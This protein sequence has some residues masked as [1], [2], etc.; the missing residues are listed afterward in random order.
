[1]CIAGRRNPGGAFDSKT[2][3][4]VNGH[5]LYKDYLNGAGRGLSSP[6][7][8]ASGAGR[9][10]SCLALALKLRSAFPPV[11]P[12]FAI[13]SSSFKYHHRSGTVFL[14]IRYII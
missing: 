10:L 1:M 13:T 8:T 7:E 12:G 11:H 3:R 9:G 4:G 14:L 2:G 6:E 5:Y